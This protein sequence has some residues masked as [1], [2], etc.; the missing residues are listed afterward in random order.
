M[1]YKEVLRVEIS[2]SDTPLAGRGGSQRQ[3]G[4][5][6]RVVA[7][8]GTQV[9]LGRGDGG[10]GSGAE[11]VRGSSDEVQLSRLAG[12]SRHQAGLDRGRWTPTV[13]DRLIPVGGPDLPVAHRRPACR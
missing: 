10:M 11:M 12:I 3:I 8:D 1:A 7:G 9:H 4:E 6:H 5:G 2:G 13:E